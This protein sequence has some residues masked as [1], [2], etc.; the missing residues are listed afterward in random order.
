MLCPYC[1]VEMTKGYIHGG[2]ND[3]PIWSPKP[4]KLFAL[5]PGKDELWV[6]DPGTRKL[7][8]AYYCKSCRKIIVCCE[9]E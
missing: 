6:G 8:P 3:T 4:E 7:P 2:R 5:L 9:E 1:G